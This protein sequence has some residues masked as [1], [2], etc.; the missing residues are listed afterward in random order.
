MKMNSK[1]NTPLFLL[2]R[3][4]RL[5]RWSRRCSKAANLF[6]LLG[7]ELRFLCGPARIRASILTTLLVVLIE[8]TDFQSS[9]EN[10]YKRESLLT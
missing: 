1:F 10:L 4:A 5:N 8:A 6:P 9:A 3:K 7:I 2:L